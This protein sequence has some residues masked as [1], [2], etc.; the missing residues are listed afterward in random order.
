MKISIQTRRFFPFPGKGVP[1]KF[2]YDRI[3]TE[4]IYMGECLRV[5]PRRSEHVNG[6]LSHVHKFGAF[7]MSCEGSYTYCVCKHGYNFNKSCLIFVLVFEVD[8]PICVGALGVI[9]CLLYCREFPLF[10]KISLSFM[11]D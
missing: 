7:R 1:V 9:A 6:P 8:R 11:C 4:S 2:N 5:R 10:N 3:E